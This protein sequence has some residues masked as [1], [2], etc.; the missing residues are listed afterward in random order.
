[1]PFSTSSALTRIFGTGNPDTG[2]VTPGVEETFFV[3]DGVLEVFV[4]DESGNRLTT[5]LGKWDCITCPPGVIHGNQPIVEG[6]YPELVDGKA[7][8]GMGAHKHLVAALQ[9]GGDGIDLAAI[10]TTRRV[11]EIP[12][13]RDLPV[14]PDQAGVLDRAVEDH[15]EDGDFEDWIELLNRGTEPVDLEGWGLSD[16]RSNPFKWTFPA[17]TLRRLA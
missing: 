4:E 17:V 15:D 13:R 3:L 9:E 7:E 10:V 14:G 8:G 5:R 12:F 2:L 16:S 11:A 1:L 6:F